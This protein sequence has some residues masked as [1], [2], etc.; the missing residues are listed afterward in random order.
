MLVSDNLARGIHSLADALF[1][2]RSNGKPAEDASGFTIGGIR[3]RIR[4]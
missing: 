1:G 4:K 2:T 3:F